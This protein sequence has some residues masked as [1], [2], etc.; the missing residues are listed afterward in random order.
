MRRIGI[1]LFPMMVLVFSCGSGPKPVEQTPVEPAA[2]V[3]QP[4]APAPSTPPPPPKPAPAPAPQTVQTAP[5]TVESAPAPEK[6]FDPGSVSEEKYKTTKADI[7]SLIEELNKIIRARNY[8]AWV[9]YLADSYFQEIGSQ[10]FLA[11]RTEELYK[12]DQI[13]AS[14]LGRDPKR[15]QKNILRTPKDYFDDIVVPSRSNDRM[16]DIDFI[17][18]NRVKAYTVD[19]RGN[20]LVLYDLEQIDGKWKIIN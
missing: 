10:D 6:A 14:N 2:Q 4:A 13:V 19:S 20:R 12:R 16:D 3:V 11:A 18:E 15:V 9:S 1:L 7:N 17:S 5:E 8:N